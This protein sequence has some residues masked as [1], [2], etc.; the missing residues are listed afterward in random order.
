M[1]E[2]ADAHGSGPCEETH[3]GSNPFDRT[4]EEHPGYQ[5]AFFLRCFMNI[6]LR[7][8][9]MICKKCGTENN[10]GSKFCMTCGETLE[11][12]EETVNI[13]NEDEVE[14]SANEP[15]I[16]DQSYTNDESEINNQ[17][18]TNNEPEIIPEALHK[19]FCQNC[20][21]ELN[22][23]MPFCGFCGTPAGGTS[24]PM[25]GQANVF[26]DMWDMFKLSIKKPMD[27]IKKGADEKYAKVAL[28]FLV[29]KDV[30]LAILET[31][32]V[33]NQISGF[34]DGILWNLM[35]MNKF[36]IFIY[37]LL[38]LAIIDAM[39]VLIYVAAGKMFGSSVK[40]SQW[41]GN[42]A[43]ANSLPLI[44]FML[45]IILGYSGAAG[46][47]VGMILALIGTSL[48]NII[49]ILGFTN[50]MKIDGNRNVYAI[51][52]AMILTSLAL[53]IIFAIIGGA[54]V[55]S[56]VPEIPSFR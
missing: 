56:A 9:S 11:N 54:A 26:T 12:L 17:P 4:K 20:G 23:G 30:I 51:L 50:I 16:N 47:T 38:F 39:F 14:V 19:R 27:A 41:I 7:R 21:A 1:A 43:T 31:V 22:E 53:L 40:I 44:F 55:Q 15:E 37:L 46:G 52:V 2:L 5:G 10:P 24:R 6:I 29:I 18:E 33:S 32:G 35:S 8:N 25:N 3:G 28:L 45:S 36:Q 48:I 49:T 42:V 34:L 13:T